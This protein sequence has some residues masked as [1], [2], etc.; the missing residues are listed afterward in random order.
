MFYISKGIHFCPFEVFLCLSVSCWFCCLVETATHASLSNLF[1][2]VPPKDPWFF[3]KS[4]ACYNADGLSFV[5]VTTAVMNLCV[6]L[7]RTQRLTT[8]LPILQ[9]LHS[10]LPPSVLQY[11]L[12]LRL[13]NSDVPRPELT[14][15]TDSQDIPQLEVPAMSIFHCEWTLLWARLSAA[16]IYGYTQKHLEESLILCPL[17]KT[18]I[19]GSF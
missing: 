13:G 18:A 5:R 9:L 14:T 1:W 11:S 12:S 3:F 16:L 17:T 10:I 7:S 15:V 4:E 2:E 6:Q 8:F 19:V